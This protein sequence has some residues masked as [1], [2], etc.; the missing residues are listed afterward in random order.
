MG[1]VRTCGSIEFVGRGAKGFGLKV[2][3]TLAVL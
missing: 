1:I 2:G 3:G